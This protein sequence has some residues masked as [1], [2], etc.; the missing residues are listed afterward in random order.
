MNSGPLSDITSLGIPCQENI[1]FVWSTNVDER[2]SGISLMSK[3]R[4][5]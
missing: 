1:R 4:E 3:K 5:V 2:L